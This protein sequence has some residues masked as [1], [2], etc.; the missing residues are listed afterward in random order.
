MTRP[1]S[2]PAEV[3]VGLDVGTTGVKA[4]AFEPGSPWRCT[5]VRE[6][7]LLQPAPDQYVQDP[8][9]LLAAV[10]DALAECVAAASG[11]EVVGVSVSAGMHGLVAL[12]ADGRPLTPLVT[13]ADAR[14]R[15]EA[16][17]LHQS[18]RARELHSRTGVPV[19]SM[20]PLTKLRW[21]AH[22]EP[23]LWRAA[24]WWAG[25]KELLL[26]W[27]TGEMVTELSSASGTGML[28]MTSRTWSREAVEVAGVDPDRLPP[29]VAT[30]AIYPL[31]AGAAG[32]VGLPVGTPVVV[33][34]AD[35]PLGNLGTGALS[36]GVAGLSLGTS[37][38]VRM[39]VD[40]PTVD[41][42]GT[43][44]CYALTDDVWVVGGAVSN[45]GSIVRWLADTIA[46]DIRPADGDRDAAVL[47]L[48]DGVP[49][50]SDGLVMLPY[51]LPER[52]PLWDPD[53]PGAYVGLR[54]AHTRGHLVRAAVEG[55]CA[56]MRVLL[57]GLDRVAPVT[58]V[59][60]TGGAFGNAI[61]RD[62]MA[63][64]AG[65]PLY[66]EDGAGGTALGAAALG[67]LALGRAPSLA[68]A[69][70]QLG[71]SVDPAGPP[72]AVD[73]AVVATYEQVRDSV[74]GMVANLSRAAQMIDRR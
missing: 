61:W 24:R 58:T 52:A 69:S 41:A 45:G 14:A 64:V 71:V 60:A 42:D 17:A 53:L 1:D 27:L 49:P 29:V 54:R 34:A 25:L 16:R 35:G 10:R 63:A 3:V 32:D 21:F 30:T 68:D 9:T 51:V 22:H 55:V 15:T 11:A 19:H 33:G 72:V 26:W 57:D 44:F 43:L 31:A 7:P 4:S 46:P 5:V 28:D 65:R 73:P 20:S 37:G 38:A 56:Q 36:P 12:D 74:S 40:R 39:A 18:G 6:Y 62:V 2:I 70:A 48:A 66:L 8:G 13:W 59:R 23:D 47:A 50:G 67:L